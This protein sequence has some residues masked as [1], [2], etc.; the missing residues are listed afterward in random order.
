MSIKMLILSIFSAQ[1]YNKKIV[2]YVIFLKYQLLKSS[3]KE[4]TTMDKLY[5]SLYIISYVNIG[6]H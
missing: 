5:R 1:H 2:T 6:I 4:A 3:Y